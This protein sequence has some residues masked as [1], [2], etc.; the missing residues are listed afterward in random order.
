MNN[1]F[2]NKI[3]L[4]CTGNEITQG[5]ILNTN[6]RQITQE[7]FSHGL[8]PNLQI[9]APDDI[10]SIEKAITFLL[11]EHAVLIITGGLGPTS[12]DKTRYAL[13]SYLNKPLL[14]DKASTEKLENLYKKIKKPFVESA[15]QQAFFPEGSSIIENPVGSANG[16][17]YEIKEQSIFMLPGPPHE[18]LPMFHKSILPKLIHRY[19]S[20][21]KLL[22][23]KLFG[24]LEGPIAEKLDHLLETYHCETGYRLDYPYIDFKILIH[25]HHNQEK[26]IVKL[27][28]KAIA[29]YWLDNSFETAS[30]RLKN[31]LTHFNE[32]VLIHDE[33][34]G[35]ILASRVLVPD[36]AATLTFTC[37]CSQN[38]ANV[39]CFKITG[40]T[41]Y[42]Q[43][44]STEPESEIQISYQQK[45]ETFTLPFINQRLP[46]YAAEFA[47]H[48][49]YQKLR[50]R[51]Y[52]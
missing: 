16:C 11:Q 40:L 23:W 36:N 29:P 20:E 52:N 8:E 41:N 13:A 26:D 32:A 27:I 14:E 33:A 37:S 49:I 45:T 25:K 24:A 30:E 43:K 17:T 51:K 22:K 4:L 6:A 47:A 50:A 42:W 28:E 5:D 18:C 44:K 38:A 15:R 48:H 1:K 46:E 7:L 2:S 21:K 12:D 35:G 31:F 34:T 3:A 9:A 19:A 39:H 10:Q